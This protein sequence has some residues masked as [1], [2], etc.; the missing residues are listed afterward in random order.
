MTVDI[1]EAILQ[2]LKR[3]DQAFEG[4]VKSVDNSPRYI[5][6]INSYNQAIKIIL[7][8]IR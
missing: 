8:S 3:S 7:E 1:K 2:L 5:R 4:W 6:E